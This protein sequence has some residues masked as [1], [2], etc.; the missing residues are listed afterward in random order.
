[1][2]TL[3][4]SAA[5]LS[6][7]VHLASAAEPSPMVKG[8]LEQHGENA[9]AV[10]RN[11]TEL[12]MPRAVVKEAER[13]H[14]RIKAATVKAATELPWGRV[15]DRSQDDGVQTKLQVGPVESNSSKDH[16]GYNIR[17]VASE[18]A[19]AIALEAGKVRLASNDN[20]KFVSRVIT[21]LP[22]G[23]LGKDGTPLPAGTLL[24]WRLGRDREGNRARPHV[25][26]LIKTDRGFRAVPI[27]L[28]RAIAYARLRP[29]GAP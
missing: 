28:A 1:M 23:A 22:D 24:S 25:A 26:L 20:G 12:G 17:R 11:L 10:S 29:P 14:R 4:V 19:E 8:A 7:L 2:R 27:T 13:I 6:C 3:V 16:V 18:Q 15:D 9:R 21:R 5:A